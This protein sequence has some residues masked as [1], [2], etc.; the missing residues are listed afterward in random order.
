MVELVGEEDALF[1]AV[2]GLLKD[3]CDEVVESK[4]FFCLVSPFSDL[5]SKRTSRGLGPGE[6]KAFLFSAAHDVQEER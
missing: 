5:L 6:R 4:E 1:S 2:D 3:L